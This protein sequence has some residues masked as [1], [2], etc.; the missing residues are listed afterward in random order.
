MTRLAAGFAAGFAA[1]LAAS[2][3]SLAACSK[4]TVIHPPAVA[5]PRAAADANFEL[6]AVEVVG[7]PEEDTVGLVKVYVDGEL[8]GQTQAGPRSSERRWHGK[9][10]P[11]NRLL[12]LEQW[13]VGSSG[14][15]ELMADEF[16]P[17]ER[18][19]RVE[20]GGRT[21]VVLKF[22]DGGRKNALQVS[23]DP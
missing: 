14:E 8:A 9:L 5:A 4:Q 16:Q 22:S 23:R 17:R 13:S 11:G 7:T 12:R 18:F 6:S 1:G 19:V 15:P 21:K 10:A 3:L 20:E 2:F